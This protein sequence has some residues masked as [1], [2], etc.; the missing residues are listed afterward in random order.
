M[1]CANEN[2]LGWFSMVEVEVNSACNRKCAYCPN[3]VIERQSEQQF[4]SPKVF[5]RLI[6]EL[7]RIEYTGRIS[8]HFYNEP[9]LHPGLSDLI[10]H[11][12]YTLADVRQV[13]YTNGDFLT[14]ELYEELCSAGVAKFIVT[15]HDYRPI[16]E[17]KR[18]VVLFPNMLNLTNRGGV[19]DLPEFK[20]LQL[21]LAVPCLAPSSMLIVTIT[22]D[23][24]LCYEDAQRTVVVGNI[25]SQPLE[26]IWFS[27]HF[28]QVKK[29][30]A[31]GD[32]S[33]NRVCSL[34]NNTSHPTIETF[35]YRL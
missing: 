34:C 9:L 27:D 17:R 26:D 16:S 15:S 31:N 24:L 32:R 30:L 29:A 18:Q 3:S 12:R 21:P 5:D 10:S 33:V 14:D 7:V 8:Y 6:S 4:I 25:V 20:K 11:V 22:G 28:V 1:K 23:V 2:Y 19:V 35:D 13:L